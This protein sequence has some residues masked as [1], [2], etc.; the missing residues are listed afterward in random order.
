MI[1]RLSPQHTYEQS[2]LHP[3]LVL[4]S[5]QLLAWVL[6][7]PSAWRDYIARI[8]PSLPPDCT[9][10]ELR[11][12][13]SRAPLVQ[14][15]LASYLVYLPL[16]LGVSMLVLW[17]FGRSGDTFTIGILASMLIAI[18]YFILGGIWS[19]LAVGLVLSVPGSLIFVLGYS[20]NGGLDYPMKA[21]LMGSLIYGAVVGLV[22]GLAGH[23][24]VNISRKPLDYSQTRWSVLISGALNGILLG[25]AAIFTILNIL[26]YVIYAI[27]GVLAPG[28][29]AQS[30]PLTAALLL[31]LTLLCTAVVKWRYVRQV[32]LINLLTLLTLLLLFVVMRAFHFFQG[33]ALALPILF[34]ALIGLP[35]GLVERIAGPRIAAAAAALGLGV[36]WSIW[37]ITAFRSPPWLF[38]LPTVA[39]IIATVGAAG[40]PPAVRD[41][42]CA[43]AAPGKAAPTK[44]TLAAALA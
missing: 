44:R 6:F 19:S 29:N 43:A 4:S 36:G 9:L 42:E 39:S 22:G 17:L 20:I 23:V 26:R 41:V 25:G 28:G 21:T 31:I 30:L 12:A 15:I 5:F 13:N 8:D 32:L 34:I 27:F 40:P 2:R 18:F 37:T 35:Y 33:T 24:S 11:P 3:N 1:A 38:F 14:R 16:I 10:L 7:Q